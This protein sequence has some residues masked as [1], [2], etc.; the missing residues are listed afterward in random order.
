MEN[1]LVDSQTEKRY[2]KEVSAQTDIVTSNR[3]EP[4]IEEEVKFLRRMVQ[5]LN[6]ELSKGLSVGNAEI[7]DGKTS[8]SWLHDLRHLAPLLLAIE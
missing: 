4:M 1:E 8:A 3:D 2:S 5:K 7:L 6:V